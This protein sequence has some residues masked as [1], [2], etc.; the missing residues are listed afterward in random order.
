VVNNLIKDGYKGDIY[1]I[2]PGETEI[3]GLKCYPSVL[4]VGKPI[5]S[6]IIT[7]PAQ[8]VL[9]TTEECGQAGVKGLSIITSGFSEVGE[10]E[11]EKEIVK[12]AHKY[13]MGIIGPNIVGLLS[14]SDKYNGSFA[15]FLPLVGKSSLVTQSGALLIGIDAGTY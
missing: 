13:K 4:D 6:A 5:D 11:L 9:K 8:F 1:P 15:P 10:H 3:L 14:N 7:V 12:T 2:N